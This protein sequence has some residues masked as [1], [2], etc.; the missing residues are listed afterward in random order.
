MLSGFCVLFCF[1]PLLYFCEINFS[2]RSESTLHA[3]N[4]A[5]GI[6]SSLGRLGS[7]EP[8]P[9]SSFAASDF[10]SASE[11]VSTWC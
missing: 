10:M 6:F 4:L 9:A 11:S 1:F 2:V 7:E 3:D 8:P 5:D